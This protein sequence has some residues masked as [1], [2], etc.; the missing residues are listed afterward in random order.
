MVFQ[1]YKL[2]LYI[3]PV[4]KNFFKIT[5]RILLIGVGF[6]LKIF[7][8]VLKCRIRYHHVKLKKKR[9]YICI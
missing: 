3:F 7:L 5:Y 6:E 1:D 8:Y 9:K 2:I 4:K